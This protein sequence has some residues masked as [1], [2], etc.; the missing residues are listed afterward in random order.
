MEILECKPVST[1]ENGISVDGNSRRGFGFCGRC[2]QFRRVS[3]IRGLS[4]APSQSD[5]F[6]VAIP[7]EVDHNLAQSDRVCVVG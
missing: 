6:L 2:W 5:Q 4:R 3:A 7:T 1:G